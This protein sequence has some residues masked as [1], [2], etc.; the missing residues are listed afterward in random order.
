[1]AAY[2]SPKLE[3][4]QTAT[5]VVL[6]ASLSPDDDPTA[7]VAINVPSGRR[8]RPSRRRVPSS[9]CEG[10]RQVARHSRHR[11]AGRGSD[12]RR[13]TGS[14]CHGPASLHR[15]ERSDRDL[16][17]D[18]LGTGSDAER[19]DVPSRPTADATRPGVP[20]HLPAILR[21]SHEYA[22]T[23][24]TAGAKLYSA[25]LTINGVFGKVPLRNLDLVLDSVQPGTRHAQHG[26]RC[27]RTGGDR[28]GRGD[29]RRE[30]A[31]RG[32]TIRAV[33]QGRQPRGGR[34]R[35]R[36]SEGR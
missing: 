13:H 24:P 36:L 12:R 10:R 6:K 15:V 29:A 23:D 35:R 16:A 34:N 19:A 9:D 32:A 21:R 27:R 11:R 2:T 14:A 26:R 5:G 22:R 30:V 1:M 31:G 4:T 18:G 20:R 33:T 3:V 8:S 17:A 25:E 7:R 28:P